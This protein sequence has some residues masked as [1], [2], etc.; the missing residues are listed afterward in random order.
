MLIKFNVNDIVYMARD[1]ALRELSRDG[2]VKINHKR[3]SC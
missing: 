3:Q 2:Q 1:V